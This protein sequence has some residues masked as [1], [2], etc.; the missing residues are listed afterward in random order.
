MDSQK[1][2]K[3]NLPII[4]LSILSLHSIPSSET[5]SFKGWETTPFIRKILTLSLGL[6]FNP[7]VTPLMDP[8]YTQSPKV[9]EKL[10]KLKKYNFFKM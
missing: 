1:L 6:L 5:L 7:I 2:S 8:S 9:S 4:L 3:Y 10:F